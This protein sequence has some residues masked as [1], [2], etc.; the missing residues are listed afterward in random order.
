LNGMRKTIAARLTESKTT[1]P[2]YYVQVS[3]DM[4]KVMEIR[5]Q[6]NLN[7]EGIK[8]SVN[9]MIVKATALALRDIPD[10]NTQWAGT[11]IKK[12]KHSDV[13]VAVA[14][15]GGLITPIVFRAETLGLIEI[16]KKT[17]DIA[18]RAREGK[19]DPSEFI[20]GTTTV[21]NLG[22]LNNNT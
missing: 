15:D 16:A 5:K 8:I 7:E 2:H 4:G 18:K 3:V 11:V 9:D 20:G 14:T 19:L 1:I 17:K 22:T 12:F 10:V 13:S 6:L 21:S